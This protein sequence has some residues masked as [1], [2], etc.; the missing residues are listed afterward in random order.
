[1]FNTAG[2]DEMLKTA[3]LNF[4]T[5]ADRLPKGRLFRKINVT[6]LPIIRNTPRL[7]VP[8]VIWVNR[9]GVPFNTT[10]FFAVLFTNAGRRVATAT[11]DSFGV[12]QFS[13]VPARTVI[14]FVIRTF[15]RNGVLFRTRRIPAGVEA[16]SI[17]G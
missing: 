12:V 10:G 8:T 13:S 11:F 16:F 5:Y 4:P 15:N 17:I 1:V 3:K 2:V 14:P 9:F 6:N 7:A